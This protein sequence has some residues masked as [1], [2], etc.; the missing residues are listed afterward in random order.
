MTVQEPAPEPTEKPS[1]KEKVAADA[2]RIF[3]ESFVPDVEFLKLHDKESEDVKLPDPAKPAKTAEPIND[4]PILSG[5]IEKEDD[6]ILEEDDSPDEN[7]VNMTE[8]KQEYQRLRQQLIY[9]SGGFKKKDSEK[10]I[11][12]IDDSGAPKKVSRFKAARIS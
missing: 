7:A 12:P 3:D 5:V 11:E 10:E 4:K 8:I 2:Q 1:L 9:E 6:E